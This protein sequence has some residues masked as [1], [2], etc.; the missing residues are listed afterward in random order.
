[1]S[2]G[3]NFEGDTLFQS[4]ATT[5]GQKYAVDFDAGIFGK[6]TGAPLQ[7]RTEIIGNGTLI[8]QLLTPPDAN[9]WDPASVQ[10]QHYYIEFTANS[11]MTTLQFTSVGL[12]NAAADQVVDTVSVSI[13]P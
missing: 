9:T 10:F 1:L 12:G 6:R 8:N 4:V 11:A 5:P 13:V 3:G 7:L 2:A